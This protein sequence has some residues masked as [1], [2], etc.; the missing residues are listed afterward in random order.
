MRKMGIVK[1][2]GHQHKQISGGAMDINEKRHG[3]DAIALQTA[4]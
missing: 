4:L 2:T 3:S 1:A